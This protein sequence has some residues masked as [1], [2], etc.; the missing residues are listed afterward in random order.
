MFSHTSDV[1]SEAFSS[2][3]QLVRGSEAYDLAQRGERLRSKF[4]QFLKM[5]RHEETFIYRDQLSSNYRQGQFDLQVDYTDLIGFDKDL[6]D[7]VAQIPGEVIPLFEQSAVR[8]VHQELGNPKPDFEQMPKFQITL[9]NY[10]RHATLRTL[11]SRSITKLVCLDGIVISTY[12]VKSKATQLKIK[13]SSCN[14]TQDIT[15]PK[16]FGDAMI[17][18]ICSTRLG[19]DEDKCKLDP[20]VILPD[21]CRFVDTQKLRLQE[22][23]EQVPTGEMPRHITMSA[24]RSLV[25]KVTPGTRVS[26][27]GIYSLF[28]AKMGGAGG[29]R[30]S[31]TVRFPYLRVVGLE[32]MSKRQHF[33]AESPEEQEELRALAR[34]PQIYEKLAA[35]LA[36]K[37]FGHEDVK[38]AIICLLFGGTRKTLP[39]RVRIRG[40][41]N[42]LLLGDPSVAKSQMLKC[43]EKSA[44]IAVYTSGKG[45][46]A[47]GLTA[48]VIR[49]Q[50]GEFHLEAGAMVLADGGCVM[51]DEFD[52]M[53]D[54][55]RVAIHE[56]M[57]QQTISIAKAGITTILNS[58]TSVLAA[59]NPTFGRYND[60]RKPA[61]NIDFETTILSRFDLIFVIRDRRDPERDHRLALHIL[62]IH[63]N[64]ESEPELEAPIDSDLFTRY[65]AFCKKN[66]R[67]H[68]SEEACDL[69][70]NHYVGFRIDSKKRM[71]EH[72]IGVIPITVRQLEAIV[73]ISESLAKMEMNEI[74]GIRHV[75]EAIRLAKVATMAA[76]AS[77]VGGSEANADV[78]NSTF[79]K[80]TQKAER[81]IRRR[82]PIGSKWG[83]SRLINEL[84]GRD[85]PEDPV[86]KAIMN[87]SNRGEIEIMNQG[88]TIFRKL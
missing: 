71:D 13:C 21:E 24:E 17:P 18:R 42:I 36:P 8:V 6:A 45:S 84:V 81:L 88:R 82:L 15:C 62:A 64:K 29:R 85:I 57:E 50:H 20:F 26:V 49:D 73:R 59:A 78:E 80:N 69:L 61:E 43:T 74:A 25:N 56:A 28:K 67:P 35:S 54:E 37:I 83:F 65:V 10:N 40:D 58:R 31:E 1:A 70:R 5:W 86:R 55:D 11:Q 79:T 44:P 33:G 4:V 2:Q 87:M 38:K 51:I 41:L 72:G 77:G 52:K 60:M 68:V 12:K 19:N 48:S 53:R 14:A 46:S 34:D 63:M 75:T 39:S 7:D 23:P 22:L 3:G 47:A 66:C 9:T 27:I 16:G 32:S 76:A 30:R